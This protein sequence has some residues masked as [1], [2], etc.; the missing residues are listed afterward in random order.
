MIPYCN[1][2]AINSA[3]EQR[4]N[5][6]SFNFLSPNI[7][8]FGQTASSFLGSKKINIASLLLQRHKITASFLNTV[9]T[10]FYSNIQISSIFFLW[11]MSSPSNYSTKKC[12]RYNAK[13]DHLHFS[14]LSFPVR[15]HRCLLNNDELEGRPSYSLVC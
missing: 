11:R 4:G 5:S 8:L 3:L 10:G 12:D 6:N 13:C 14:V 2:V 1:S 15:T 9:S 7:D